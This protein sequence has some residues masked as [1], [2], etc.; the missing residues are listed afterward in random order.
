MEFAHF[1]TKLIIGIDNLPES[2][3]ELKINGGLDSSDVYN[4]YT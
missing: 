2:I 1:D 3:I 4:C